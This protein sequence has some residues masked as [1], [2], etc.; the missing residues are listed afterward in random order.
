MTWKRESSG[1]FDY[2]NKDYVKSKV[3]ISEESYIIREND[4]VTN[5]P[6]SSG[7][8]LKELVLVS[9]N[10][11]RQG[12]YINSNPKLSKTFGVEKPWL[13]VKGLKKPE[14]L[15]SEGEIIRLGKIRMKVKEICGFKQ[16]ET[17]KV[18]IS[19][20]NVHN[21]GLIS[22]KNIT[23]SLDSIDIKPQITNKDSIS[24]R[25]C[26][27]DDTDTP[28]PLISPCYCTGTMGVVHAQCLKRWLESKIMRKVQNKAKI[29][30]WKSLE[31]ELCKFR[32]PNKIKINS[33]TI[34][35]INIE[36][37][38][39]NYIIFE[40]LTETNNHITVLSIDKNN[41]IKLGRGNDTDLKIQDISVSRNHAFIKVK[42]SS[43][44]LE[45]CNSKFGTLVKIKK[46][47]SLDLDN[48][49]LIQCGRTL[50]KLSP[51]KPWNLFG[52]FGV[53]RKSREIEDEFQ[54]TK[55]AAENIHNN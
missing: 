48:K 11:N 5:F 9:L 41:I 54:K 21:G 1:L 17:K 47:L 44:Y 35:L 13:V 12:F 37:P 32:Y 26:L 20:K 40:T 46:D 30:T 6:I 29:Y 50:L 15:L 28:N 23:E 22:N 51:A 31:C 18:S 43:L 10:K 45:D 19:S 49:V 53:C 52:C 27:G 55:E 42:N 3:K 33:N 4:V 38:A 14:Y 2:E 25:I 34:D 8:E 7:P 39:T 16:S 36:K 24:C